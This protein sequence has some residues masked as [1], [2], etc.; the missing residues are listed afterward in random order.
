MAQA[1]DLLTE[2]GWDS[3]SVRSIVE[4]A[5]APFLGRGQERIALDGPDTRVGSGKALLLAMAVHELGTNA[6]KYGALSNDAGRIQI[7]WNVDDASGRQKLLL[8]WLES[9]G[10][11]VRAPD[12]KGFGTRMIERALKGEQGAADFNFAPDGLRFV[13]SMGI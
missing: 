1:H 2:E 5:L 6:V 7:R 8:T 12:G 13:M 4:R 10:P 3:I 11:P 9:G